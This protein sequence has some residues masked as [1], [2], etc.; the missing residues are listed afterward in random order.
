M[1][2]HSI[3]L[4]TKFFLALSQ[5]MKKK[6]YK[7]DK[8]FFHII[9]KCKEPAWPCQSL[10]E[11]WYTLS[12]FLKETKGVHTHAFVMMRNH[13]HWLCSSEQNKAQLEHDLLWFDSLKVVPINHIEGYRQAYSYIYNNPVKAGIVERAELYPYSSLPYLLGRTSK[14]LKFIC[15]DEMNLI[16]D[17]IRVLRWLN[18]QSCNYK[19]PHSFS[20]DLK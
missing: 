17:P 15:W 3:R 8:K 10:D 16:C 4:E 2:S 1:I 14:K 20:L 6:I 5:T 7:H 18:H 11:V 19:E 13:Y 12:Q 9:G